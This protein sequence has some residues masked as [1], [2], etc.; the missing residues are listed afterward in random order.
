MAKILSN[1]LEDLPSVSIVIP[2]LNS[3][4]TL[5]PC[6]KSI[7]SQDY[8]RGKIEVIIV[9]GG[10][11]DETVSIAKE[12]GVER[13]LSNPLRTGEA[14]KALGVEMAKNEIIAFIDSDN[15]LTSPNWLKAMVRPFKD[16]E[17]VGTEPLYYTLR[18]EDHLITRY[19]ALVGMNDVL[20]LFLGNYD[21]YSYMT[22]KWTGLEVDTV[23]REGYILVK[24]NE[25]NIPTMGANGFLV[26]AE[27]LKSTDYVPYLFDIDMIYQ[28]VM[29]GCRKYA[30]V[31][32]GIVHVYAESLTTY[33]KKTRR[34]IADYLY[35]EKLEARKYPWRNLNKLGILKFILYTLLLAPTV[36]G[37]LR[38]YR[39]LHDKAWLFHPLSCWLTLITYA[40][41]FIVRV[42]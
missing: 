40:T 33:V 31:R 8:P 36:R 11:T 38:G 18:E 17:I 3:S 14:G 30:K 29:A 21:R 12:H 1:N 42:L 5:G 24:L 15:I 26:R 19:C 4:H 9:D 35:Y 2:T 16:Q 28:L 27:A 13:I 39:G 7:F 23:D 25:R 22:G 37:F 32:I 34:R 41:N 10:S 6:L 20:C